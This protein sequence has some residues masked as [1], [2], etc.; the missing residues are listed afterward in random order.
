MP[1]HLAL[2]CHPPGLG[3]LDPSLN[4]LL[5]ALPAQPLRAGAIPPEGVAFAEDECGVRALRIGAV[6]LHE[7]HTGRGTLDV[8]QDHLVL[9]ALGDARDEVERLGQPCAQLGNEPGVVEEGQVHAVHVA[10]GASVRPDPGKDV[11]ATHE[12]AAN[13]SRELDFV[14]L[15]TEVDHALV[16]ELGVLGTEHE[17]LR[18]LLVGDDAVEHN[19]TVE[20]PGHQ[21]PI[22][23]PG[24]PRGSLRRASL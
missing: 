24:G 9:F 14:P 8:D 20:R 12:H 22:L 3:V 6:R 10:C 7:D 1:A 2:F 23:N 17:Q 5:V 11:P 18:E 4:D 21:A 13:V 19:W 16:V 15:F